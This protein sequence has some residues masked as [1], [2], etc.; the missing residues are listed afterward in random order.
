MSGMGAVG[1]IRI[2]PWVDVASTVLADVA[3]EWIMA[4]V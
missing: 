3:A 1:T 4:A 2:S